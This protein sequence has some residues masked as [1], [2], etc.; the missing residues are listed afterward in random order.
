M[1]S[2]RIEFLFEP[3][4][5]STDVAL[6]RLREVTNEEGHDGSIEVVEVATDELAATLRFIGSPTIRID[7]IDIDPPGDET[8][9][10]LTCRA[11]RLPDGRI[12]PYPP[13]ELIRTA[14]RG[15]LRS[16][17]TGSNADEAALGGHDG[18]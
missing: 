1:D 14:L 4:C 13:K 12:T 5:S 7:G 9:Y 15:A 3:E 11:Y 17:E 8:R 2:V 16:R 18:D 6:S 10:A